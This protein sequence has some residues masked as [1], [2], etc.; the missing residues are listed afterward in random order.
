M[1]HNVMLEWE[2]L[3]RKYDENAVPLYVSYPV[4]SFWKQT[5]NPDMYANS[6]KESDFSFLYFH[7]PY[8][9]RICHYCL[10][11]K[12]AL[13]KV[14][15]ID[16]YIVYLIKEMD[17]KLN[18]ADI[19]GKLKARHMHWGGGTP[20]LLTAVQIEKI[21]KAITERIEFVRDEV[22]EFSLEAYPDEK[23]I[24]QDKLILLKELG[25]N[26]IS[27]GIQDFDERI[28]KVINRE[29][30]VKTVQSLIERARQTGFRVHVDLC[31][32]LP[33]QGLNE[34]ESTLREVVKVQPSRITMFPYAHNPFIFPRQK[35][36]PNASIPNSFIKIML[37]VMSDELLVEHGYVRLGLANYIRPDDP[38]FHDLQE[39]GIKS[40]MGYSPHEKIDFLGF[41][42][43]AISFINNTFYQNNIKLKDYFQ[44]I[45]Q[46]HIP[47]DEN[48]SYRHNEDDYIRN[49]LIQKHILTQFKIDKKYFARQFNVDFDS[50]FS[51]EIKK[52]GRYEKDG[53]VD[54]HDPDMIRITKKGQFFCR[55]VA[56][57]FDTFYAK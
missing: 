50:Y 30:G 56:H 23:I 3:A 13:N 32:G 48:R 16:A 21:H 9:K 12:E 10:C 5:V 17:L 31:Y 22:N 7:F 26:S 11:Y 6:L 44:Q 43:T 57:V 27:F 41:G 29:H 49:I 1:K 33:F 36:I 35:V 19:A 25:F 47:L 34:L 40:L 55:H 54:L 52:L 39:R 37:A 38:F 45:D 24:T 53:L 2:K 8:C 20:T 46:N 42:S 14:T 4:E 18:Q 28:Q 51:G 15:D